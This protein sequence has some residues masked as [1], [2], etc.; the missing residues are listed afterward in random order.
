MILSCKHAFLP[1]KWMNM[2]FSGKKKSTLTQ[3]FNQLSTLCVCQLHFITFYPFVLYSALI[4]IDYVVKRT[5]YCDKV[6][7]SPH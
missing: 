1:V 3:G 2:K 5:A 7:D 6:S 4:S